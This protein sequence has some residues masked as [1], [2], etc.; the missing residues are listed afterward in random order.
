MNKVAASAVLLF[1]SLAANAQ[2]PPANPAPAQP[3]I[4]R[5]WL[6]HGRLATWS[7]GRVATD[8]NSHRQFFEAIG[9]GVVIAIDAH[10]GYFVTAKH[11]FYDPELNWHPS[12]VRLRFA[13]QEDKSVFNELGVVLT[14]RDAAGKDLWKSLDD[15]SDLAAIVPPSDLKTEIAEAISL[16]D[17]AQDADLYQG[18]SAIV[19]GYPGV[20]GKE[21]L[22]RAIVRQGI[23]A[24]TNP[25]EP[26]KNVF[27]VDANLFPGNSGS[28]VFRLPV[29]LTREGAFA[30]GGRIA[31][32][33]IVTRGPIQDELVTADGKPIS[34][35]V[36][37]GKSPAPMRVRVVGIGGIGVTEPAS[38]VLLLVQSFQGR[39]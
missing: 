28:P 9:T 20:V 33:G 21:Y 17:F 32:L 12:E 10:T 19:L 4:S 25:A 29:G 7:V 14:L 30:A 27:L 6:D 2:Q 24:W 18:A 22:I 3:P 13:W 31:F 38:K 34:F 15:G 16:N 26:L 37:P 39:K 36:E 1:A 8:E 5:P 23:V 11:V 35:A